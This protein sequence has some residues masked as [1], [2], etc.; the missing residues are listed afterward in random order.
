MSDIPLRL[1]PVCGIEKDEVALAIHLMEN[2]E[3]NYGKAMDWIVSHVERENE[4]A[5]L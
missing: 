3:W 1:C 4:D 5:V 2:H